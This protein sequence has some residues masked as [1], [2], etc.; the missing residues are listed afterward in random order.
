MQGITTQ[1]PYDGKKL[2]DGSEIK[3]YVSNE[4]ERRFGYAEPGASLG[5]SLPTT[6]C[7]IR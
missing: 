5:D 3:K 1:R 2:P 4:E 6:R 7:K